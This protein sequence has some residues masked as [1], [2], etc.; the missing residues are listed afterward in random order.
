MRKT[1][2]LIKKTRLLAGGV[3]T[4][5]S[6]ILTGHIWTDMTR[7][8]KKV[9]KPQI[10]KKNRFGDMLLCGVLVATSLDLM[11]DV[12]GAVIRIPLFIMSGIILFFTGRIVAGSL[13]KS[14]KKA[15]YALVL[16][17]ALEDGKPTKDLIY[18]VE[19][20][21]KYQDEN[22]FST[23]V[24]T[25]GNPGEDGK[26]EAE[27]M[28]DL[29][30]ARGVPE[31]RMILEDE[32]D[33]TRK[34]FRNTLNIIDSSKPIILITSNYHMNRAVRIAKR[35]GFKHVY[36]LPAKSA[37]APYPANVFWEVLHNINEYL[38]IVKEE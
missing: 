37:I 15:D 27:V 5:L 21:K 22:P 19:A 32:S 11:L 25:G 14:G 10:Y 18:R 24:L 16:G 7:R 30:L 36:A 38:R 29:L 13:R 1:N 3:L 33:S 4:L 17:M 9:A 6:L 31:C 20:A 23:L 26:T 8:M 34:N 2:S 35:A 12:F 28:R